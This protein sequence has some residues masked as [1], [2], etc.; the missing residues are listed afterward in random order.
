MS[1]IRVGLIG[2]GSIAKIA[3]VPNISANPE[4]ELVAVCDNDESKA[5]ETAAEWGAKQWFSD[6]DRF[7]ETPMDVVVIAT[8]PLFHWEQGLAA[9]KAGVHALIEKPMTATAFEARDLVEAFKASG[10]KL[11]VGC[12]RRYWLQSQW[13]KQLIDDGVIG[14]LHLGRSTMHEGW[15]LYQG[16]IAETGFR[17]DPALSG[18]AALADTGAHAIDL[19]VWLIGSPVKRVVGV[20]SRVATPAEYSECDD[21]A[22]VMMEHENGA[23]GYVS[24]NR[25]T[26]A[27][28]H[29]TECY[30][31]HGTIFL[32]SDSINPYQTA[33]M[34]VFTDLDHNWDEL[35][36]VL[37]KYRWPQTFWAEDLVNQPVQKRW[38]PIIPPREPNN[39][40][41]LW[42]HFIE[43]IL[44]DNEPLTKGEDGAH[45][46]EVMCAVYESMRT[47]GWVELPLREDVSPPGYTSRRT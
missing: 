41:R 44:E 17:L 18:G 2:C 46:V 11:M 32:G 36:D 1:E 23:H 12:D 10:K 28:S 20:A 40:Q 33:P 42:R 30:G 25:F 47:G 5:K 37:R 35:P 29:F 19:L 9:A 15:P 27:A 38:V 6:E 34:A 22:L 13:T 39:Y 43:C 8:P 16:L 45:A 24:C 14:Q 31:D 21:L 4:T 26:P 3:H 7:F